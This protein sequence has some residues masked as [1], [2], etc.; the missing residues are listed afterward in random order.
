[1]KQRL[2]R[3]LLFAPLLLAGGCA[4]EAMKGT[5]F[6]AGEF[7]Q[8]QGPVEDRVNLWPLLYYRDPA[9]S[10][11]WPVGE[12]VRKEQLAV[13]PLFSVYHLD[14]PE[15]REWNVLWPI[16]QQDERSGDGR[17]RGTT[18]PTSASIAFHPLRRP[19]RT[20]ASSGRGWRTPRGG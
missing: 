6:F 17:E 9:L 5:P 4:T 3:M 2:I 8:R 15:G 16:F 14:Q 10:L 19:H 1:M 13:R 20:D 12:Y 7:R 18:V 11:L